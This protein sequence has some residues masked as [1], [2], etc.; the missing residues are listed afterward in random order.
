VARLTERLPALAYPSARRY[1]TARFLGTAAL[2]MQGVAVGWHVYSL[3]GNPLDLGLIGLFQFLPFVVFVLPAGHIADRYERR[4]IIVACYALE[5]VGSLALVGLT[6]G[7]NR[8]VL[9]IF[10]VM[11]LVGLVRAFS[12]PANQ[13]LLPGLVPAAAFSSAVALRS[14]LSQV[15]TITGPAVA[16]FLL[17]AGPELAYG[18]VAVLVVMAG[19]SVYAMPTVA[20]A[21][22][23]EPLGLTSLLAGLNFVRH[24]RPVLGAISLDLFAVL[25][26]GAVALLP[27][28]ATDVLHVGP[29]GLGMLRAAPAVGAVVGATAMAA[30]PIRRRVGTWLFGGVAVYGLAIVTFGLSTVFVVSLA[31]LT[32]LGM[33]D[34]ISVYVRQVL[35][36]LQTPDAIRGRVSA[37]NS[38]SVGASSELGE[39]ESGL[40]A[41]WWTVVPAVL[42]GGIAT[43]AVT[44]AWA[45]LFPELRTLDRFPDPEEEAAAGES[46]KPP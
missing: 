21:G 32:V 42:V 46:P 20:V 41:A 2:Q 39:F 35:V 31:A 15:A 7:G 19:A 17:L 12:M 44:V 18:L 26:G 11:A 24:N 3:T 25:F 10:G 1:L 27:A 29:T 4:R 16:G 8:D 28:F 14:S 40:T 9:P 36:Q 45:L 23:R 43:L 30:R 33:A 22:A 13:A 5:A 6:L 34:V 38:V 37:V